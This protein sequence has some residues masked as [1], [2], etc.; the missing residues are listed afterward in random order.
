MTDV[1]KHSV[2]VP[3]ISVDSHCMPASRAPFSSRAVSPLRPHR[4]RIAPDVRLTHIRRPPHMDRM[5]RGTEPAT[6]E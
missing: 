2:Y 6:G 1:C 5:I 4:L 3:R